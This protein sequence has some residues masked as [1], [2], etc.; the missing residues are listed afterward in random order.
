M[1]NLT[2]NDQRVSVNK[3]STVLDAAEKLGINIPTL[4]YYKGL[5]PNASCMICV[6]HDL[7]TDSLLPS[8][9]LP[10]EDGMKIETGNEKVREARKDTLDLLLSEHVGD[11]EAICSRACPAEMDIPLMIRQIEENDLENAIITVKKDIALPA[12]LG[13][14]CSAPCE[15]GC[16]RKFYDEPVSICHL[17]K[18]VADADLAKEKQYIPEI[19]PSTG[20][21]VAVI[22]A[23]PAGLSSAYY[24][25]QYGHKCCIFDRNKKPGGML[26]YGTPD[27]ILPK[28]VLKAEID[29]IL[30]LGI[31]LRSEQTLGK[32]F[33]INDL[34]KDFDAVVITT[35]KIDPEIFKSTEIELSP[36]GIVVNRKTYETSLAGVFTGG[37]T[38][39]EGKSAIRS[40]AHGKFIAE[41][42]DNF[43]NGRKL[44]GQ[45]KRFNSSIGKLLESEIKEFVKE[46]EEW[47]RIIP[48]DNIDSGYTAEEAEKET[49]R[50]CHCDCRKLETCKLRQ[51]SDEYGADQSRFKFGQRKLIQKNL[52]HDL[53]NFEPGKCIKCN[54]CV[55][56]TK[57]AGEKLGL[58]FINRGFDIRISVP[59]NESLNN[60][61][62][63]TAEECI[64]ACPTAAFAWKKYE[65]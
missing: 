50:C 31:E 4:C 19:K 12:V 8:C 6:V 34:R 48:G 52:Q 17:K 38:I 10:A 42:V 7:R 54:I 21:K 59:F 53:V 58:T 39:S 11:C 28:S 63:K 29:H 5:E 18:F 41:S 60:G 1:I 44:T 49:G 13:R 62:R 46:A 23:G 32:D 43:L 37:N 51:Y 57:K 25:T 45:N 16:K 61:L 26:Q 14:I 3:G 65:E 36:R 55:E 30:G 24:I 35:G 33:S 15:K 27:D 20:K 2:I 47:E 56:I 9:S 40:A 22:G 64:N